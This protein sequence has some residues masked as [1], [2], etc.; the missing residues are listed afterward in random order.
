MDSPFANAPFASLQRLVLSPCVGVC[1]LGDD[2]LCEGCGRTTTEIAAW[3]AMD[4]AARLRVME[5]L[6]QRLDAGGDSG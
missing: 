4:D 1:R 6:E 3:P 5:R 2:G